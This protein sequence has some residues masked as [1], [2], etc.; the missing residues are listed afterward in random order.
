MSMVQG[1][2]CGA[3]TNIVFTVPATGTATVTRGLSSTATTYTYIAYVP[4]VPK[5]KLP[6]K[7]PLHCFDTKPLKPKQP[8]IKPIR[9]HR[10]S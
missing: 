9:R 6:R 5:V 4:S 2:T 8:I 1:I 7:H 10:R 3:G